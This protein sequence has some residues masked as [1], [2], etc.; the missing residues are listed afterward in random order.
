M[1][2]AS[3]ASHSMEMCDAAVQADAKDRGLGLVAV[4]CSR[5]ILVSSMGYLWDMMGI[6]MGFN[7]M[8]MKGIFM[9]YFW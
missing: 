8:I 2:P 4:A 1:S 3:P 5:E 7:G 9:G 6:F